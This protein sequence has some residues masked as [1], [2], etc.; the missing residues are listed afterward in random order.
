MNYVV[1]ELTLYRHFL[2][3]D[4]PVPFELVANPINYVPHMDGAKLRGRD[5]CSRPAGAW[6]I[7]CYKLLP[8]LYYKENPVFTML[9]KYDADLL[10]DGQKV[11]IRYS[12]IDVGEGIAGVN[13]QLVDISPNTFRPVVSA[14]DGLKTTDFHFIGGEVEPTVSF[15]LVLVN[16]FSNAHNVVV[17]FSGFFVT[18]G[19]NFFPA[20]GSSFPVLYNGEWKVFNGF[21]KTIP[22]ESLILRNNDDNLSFL[23]GTYSLGLREV[24]LNGR[25]VDV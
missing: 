5:T 12:D 21:Y 9:L 20:F 17:E 25:T 8:S 6:R 1:E 16:F 14:I 3:I 18:G 10:A 24:C 11:D 22:Q 7:D 2:L 15:P 13:G 4:S 23:V 19:R